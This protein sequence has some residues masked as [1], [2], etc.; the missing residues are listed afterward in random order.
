[1][2]YSESQKEA[3]VKYL[4][5]LKEIRFRVKHEVYEKYAAA[6]KKAGY[7]DMRPFYMDAIKEK[8]ERDGLGESPID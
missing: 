5:K 3:T 6:A 7:E 1:M 8:I 2:A 4:K